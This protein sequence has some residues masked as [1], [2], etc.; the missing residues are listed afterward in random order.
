MS[1]LR[2]LVPALGSLVGSRRIGPLGL[3]LSS[4]RLHLV[5]M[6][7]GDTPSVRAA[8]SLPYRCTRDALLSEPARLRRLVAEALSRQPFKGRGVVS[9]LPAADVTILPVAFRPAAGQDDS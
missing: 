5:Q 9:S 2:S 4:E 7:L 6:Q 1:A 3:E 8:V